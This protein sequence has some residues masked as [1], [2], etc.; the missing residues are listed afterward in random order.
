MPEKFPCMIPVP[1]NAFKMLKDAGFRVK[2]AIGRHVWVQVDDSLAYLDVM[3]R[4]KL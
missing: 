2:M 4:C 1:K 3:A